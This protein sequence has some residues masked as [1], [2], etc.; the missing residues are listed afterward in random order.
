[1][2]RDQRGW[3]KSSMPCSSATALSPLFQSKGFDQCR[4]LEQLAGI[5]NNEL[6]MPFAGNRNLYVYRVFL[7]GV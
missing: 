3:T 4:L 7:K 2:R 5:G 6:V 1:M